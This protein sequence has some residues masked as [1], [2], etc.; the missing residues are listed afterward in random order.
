MFNLP[1]KHKTLSLILGD[2]FILYLSLFITLFVRYPHQFTSRLLGEH[3]LPFSIVYIAW[4]LVL[5]F[6]SLYDTDIY[7]KPFA[8]LKSFFQATL[9]N[10]SLAIGFFY[11][12]ASL[13]PGVIGPKRNLFFVVVF[14]AILFYL[15]RHVFFIFIRSSVSRTKIAFIGFNQE[16]LEIIKK[17]DQN[18]H[19]GYKT[20]FIITA[21]GKNSLLK[22]IPANIKTYQG[23]SRLNYVLKDTSLTKIIIA[24]RPEN[25]PV[26]AKELYHSSSN[27][28]FVYFPNFY[29]EIASKIPLEM[30][31]RLWL[32]QGGSKKSYEIFKWI[33]DTLLAIICALTLALMFPFIIIA[34]FLTDGFPVFF[35]QTRVGKNK[36]KFKIIKLR[37]MIKEAEREKPLWAEENDVRVTKL[38]R[39]LRKTY[40]DEFPQFLN[41]LKGEMSVV[42]PRPERPEFTVTLEKEI[43]FYPLRHSVKPGVTG[44]AQVNSF[45]ARSI[46]DS[47]E[48][49]KFD[50]FYVKNRSFLFDLSILMKT[51]K[52]VFSKREK[53][54]Y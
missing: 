48:K 50:L 8:F 11:L 39:F 21:K 17:I 10:L 32:H 37:T 30:I 6:N 19:L 23:F 22:K 45:Y 49:T 2:I 7:K 27:F 29:E 46:D 31:N 4:L 15:W 18:P 42:G 9:I 3:I 53:Q 43:P 13:N 47:I 25:N 52:M 1:K 28:K 44:W 24:M 34:Y 36:E 16:V 12:S 54:N 14:F 35:I 20:E 33:L 51:G 26:L 40:I 38:G 5:Y 41:I